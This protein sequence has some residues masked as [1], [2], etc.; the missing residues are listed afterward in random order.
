MVLPQPNDSPPANARIS[1]LGEILAAGLMRLWAAKSSGKSDKLG[2][3]S[4]DFSVGQSG[5]PTN[6]KRRALDV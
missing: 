5:D 4:L 1:E 2:E 3:S 6:A